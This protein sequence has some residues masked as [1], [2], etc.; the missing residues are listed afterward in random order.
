MYDA[1]RVLF[2]RGRT[3]IARRKYLNLTGNVDESSFN[4]SL[5]EKKY[6]IKI[7]S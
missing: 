2:S 4:S 1:C 6:W 7:F 3:G 5:V